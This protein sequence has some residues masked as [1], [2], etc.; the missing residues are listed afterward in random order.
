MYAAAAEDPEAFWGVHGRRLDWIKPYSKVKN[1]SFHEADFRIRWYEDG[2][3][4]VAANCIDRHLHERGD[5]VAILWEGDDPSQSKAITYRTLHSEVCRFANV[6]KAHGVQKGDPVTIYMPMIPEAA[7]A[8]LACAR[9]GAIHSVVFGGFASH[10]LASRIDDGAPKLI[11]SADAGARGGRMIP[12]K[13]L[14]DEAMTASRP[15]KAWLSMAQPA[16]RVK[17]RASGINNF[18]VVWVGRSTGIFYRWC[19]VWA[20]VAGYCGAKF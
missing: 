6:L 5:K 17:T 11:V 10:A 15:W 1:V 7:Y 3:L 16:P 20:S 8:M 9:I 4:N 12:Y 14:L 13:G 19:D 2:V 18:F